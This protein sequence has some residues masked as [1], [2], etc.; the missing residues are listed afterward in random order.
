MGQQIALLLQL[1]EMQPCGAL[2]HD[3]ILEAGP[4]AV[5][6]SSML[7][8]YTMFNLCLISVSLLIG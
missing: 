8:I 6:F 1:V 4:P 2:Q 3:Q 5:S 7:S